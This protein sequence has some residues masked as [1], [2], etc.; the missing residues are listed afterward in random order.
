M[1]PPLATP[2]MSIWF[3]LPQSPMVNVPRDM[4]RL[5]YWGFNELF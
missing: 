2:L 5:P 3:E 4:V 1:P